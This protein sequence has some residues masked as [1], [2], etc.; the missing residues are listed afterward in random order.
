[1]ITSFREGAPRKILGIRYLNKY[2]IL[3]R[4]I[5][6]FWKKQFTEIS[7]VFWSGK[8]KTFLSYFEKERKLN[9][10]ATVPGLMVLFCTNYKERKKLQFVEW[11]ICNAGGGVRPICPR[12][13]ENEKKVWSKR[14]AKPPRRGDKKAPLQVK[15]IEILAVSLKDGDRAEL[16]R[17]RTIEITINPKINKYIISHE[18]KEYLSS[19]ERKTLR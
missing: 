4:W 7:N 16:P 11:H 5:D 8:W 1:M 6:L 14:G 15:M 2:L 18:Y 12:E 10:L 19:V 17:K 13:S 3:I 9:N